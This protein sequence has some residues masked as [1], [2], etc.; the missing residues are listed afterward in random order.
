MTEDTG[1]GSAAAESAFCNTKSWE[2]L[3]T[4]RNPKLFA[5]AWL[6]IQSRLIS[7]E[8]LQGVVV[9]GEPD[10][11]PFAPIAVWP[12]GSLGSPGLASA[13]ENA[14]GKRHST[15][16]TARRITPDSRQKRD[17]IAVP[18]LVDKQICGAVAVEIEH[19]AEDRQQQVMEQLEWGSVWLETLVHRNRFTVSD[20]LVTVLELVATG[21]QHDRFQAAAT[22]VATELAGILHCERVSIGFLRGQHSKVRALSHSASF[23]K[24]A[25]IIRAMEA[26]M[27]EAIEQHATVVFPAPVDGPVQVIRAHASLAKEHGTGTVC[28]VPFTEGER[29]LGAMTLERSSEEPFDA[30]TVQLCEHASSLLGPLLDVKRKD[31]R[32]LIQKAGDSLRNHTRRRPVTAFATTPGT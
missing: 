11:G 16:E 23:G 7:G 8:V 30:R 19:A 32:W 26:A 4:E 20:R 15:V 12:E 18:L 13:I 14:M 27:D 22:S 10:K 5:A 28:T 3:K 17:A 1:A 29:I 24:K 9:L 25:N 2:R 31:D 6:D 21:L